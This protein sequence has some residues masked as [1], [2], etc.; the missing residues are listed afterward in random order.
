MFECYDNMK[1]AIKDIKSIIKKIS[2]KYNTK[3]TDLESENLTLEDVK[4]PDYNDM[5][6][7]HNDLELLEEYNI[8]KEQFEVA[9]TEMKKIV[10]YCL[11]DSDLVIGLIEALNM[12]V[13]LVELSNIVGVEIMDLFTGG[14]QIRCY[15]QLYDLA[16]KRGIV[17][18]KRVVERKLSFNG[19]FVRE[20]VKG[21]HLWVICLDFA[22]LYPSI[23]QFNN[24]SVDTFIHP[25]FDKLIPDDMCNIIEFDQEEPREEKFI[26][27]LKEGDL[28]VI[29]EAEYDGIDYDDGKLLPDVVDENKEEEKKENKD[30]VTKHYRFRFI[31][32][33]YYTGLLP[34]L[35]KMLVDERNIVR[36]KMMKPLEKENEKYEKELSEI[37]IRKV[38]EDK[39]NNYDKKDID[40]YIFLLQCDDKKILKKKK[41]VFKALKKKFSDIQLSET[42]KSRVDELN[43]KIKINNTMLIVLDKRQ[44]AL[45]VSANSFFGFLGVSKGGK[46]PM[47]ECAM[48][49]TAWG[50]K[51]IEMVNKYVQDTYPGSMIV[52]NDTDSAQFLI[53]QITDPKDANY[54]VQK[55]LDEINGTETKKGLFQPPLRMEFEKLMIGLFFAP[56]MYAY[57]EVDDKGVPKLDTTDDIKKKGILSARRG[58]A[59][60]IERVFNDLLFTLLKLENIVAGFNLIVDELTKLVRNEI[61]GNN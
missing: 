46:L 10:N 16:Y 43:A 38:T 40:E 54:Y 61:L 36:K 39:S 41:D 8:Y 29:N 44:L 17:L 59:K 9:R 33:T 31:K 48:S 28:D 53:A 42:D 47:V 18:D 57:I 15:S 55:L 13:G 45:K 5:L 3:K 21:L 49:I 51:Y 35:V 34:T 26:P 24:I 25:D 37:E 23:M 60:F 50:R 27:H 56:K 20:P 30:T 6:K 19:G 14:Q 11:Q 12:W 2:V 4:L 52:Y 58:N 1:K 7:F 32:D 22:S